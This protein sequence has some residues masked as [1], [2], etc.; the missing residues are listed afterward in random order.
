[1]NNFEAITA[2]PA[3]LATFLGALP[4]LTAPWDDEFHI[5]FCAECKREDCT[6]CKR[7][8]RNNPEWWLGLDCSAASE[9]AEE[10][11]G[12]YGKYMVYK[13]GD[14][15]LVTDCFVLVPGKDHAAAAALRAY[16]AA[17]ENT[18]LAE[19]ILEWLKLITAT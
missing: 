9:V 1:M 16:A 3:A 17:T 5:R 13:A 4:I 10:R 2:S 8:E 7:P 11:R 15:A 14:G 18:E 19:D 12:L 6:D